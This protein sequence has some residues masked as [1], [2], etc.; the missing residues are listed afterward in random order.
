LS[1]SIPIHT[2][3][4]GVTKYN[5][6]AGNWICNSLRI[7]K[8]QGRGIEFGPICRRITPILLNIVLLRHPPSN[9]ALVNSILLN[10]HSS[11]L[12]TLTTSERCETFVAIPTIRAC[13]ARRLFSPEP[14]RNRKSRLGC[15]RYGG[16]ITF[17][18]S[19]SYP[20][21]L[22]SALFSIPTLAMTPPAPTLL[23]ASDTGTSSDSRQRCRRMATLALQFTK[24]G[25][26]QRWRGKLCR[27]KQKIF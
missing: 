21:I 15:R 5:F 22:L 9:I 4:G 13:V 3:P 26:C 14:I 23:H 18:R 24:V 7:K 6:A 27:T 1:N 11:S 16:C 20:L 12:L 8:L 10:R 17:P 19:V 25:N 2:I